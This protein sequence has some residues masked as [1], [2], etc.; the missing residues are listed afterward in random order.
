MG[1]ILAIPY[2]T[3]ELMSWFDPLGVEYALNG[4]AYLFLDNP[5]RTGFKSLPPM[6]TT[7]LNVPLTDGD[8]PRFT[9]AGP[10]PLSVHTLIKGSNGT[11]FE[12][13]R[14]VLQNGMNP[15]LGTG[16]FRCTRQDGTRRDINC[17]YVDGFIG[18]E[19]W[20]VTSSVHQELLLGFVAHD[21]YFYDTLATILTFTATAATNFFPITPLRLSSTSIGSGFSIFNSGD[22][23][24]FPVFTIQG[25]GTNPLL[26]NT[27]TGKALSA[28][29]TLGA[30]QVLTIDTGAKT[31]VREDGSN[32]FGTLG[33][34]SVLWSLAV[35]QN[36]LTLA[37]GGAG[38]GSQITVAYKQR[39]NSL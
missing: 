10:R 20:G 32:Q 39:W 29:I 38:A 18:D 17:K 15:K 12:Q 33:L 31:V 24:A 5:G 7:V 16:V 23:E 21:P 34:S 9:L 3:G 35:G 36:A 6:T 4:D 22:V 2:S 25:P 11:D 28:T 37:M 27:T 26:T 14:T 8:V 19:S 1:R 13:V 30:G